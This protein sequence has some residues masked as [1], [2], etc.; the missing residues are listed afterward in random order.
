MRR[1]KV[2]FWPLADM[3]RCTAHV[4]FREQSRHDHWH[5]SAFMVATGGKADMT[6][7]GQ[8]SACDPK[9]TSHSLELLAFKDIL[10][11]PHK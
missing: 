1:L 11:S 2:R 5:M 3:S 7:C 4:C 10:A 6:Y 9:R 8:M